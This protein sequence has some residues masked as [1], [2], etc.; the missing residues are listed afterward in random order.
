MLEL[1]LPKLRKLLANALL[2]DAVARLLYLGL[3]YKKR[4]HH[5]DR[6]R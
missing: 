3:V 5:A 2:C 4:Q 1:L 6:V